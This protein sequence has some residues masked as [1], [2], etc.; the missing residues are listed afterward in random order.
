MNNFIITNSIRFIFLVLLQVLVLN[1]V[2]FFGYINPVLYILF[3]FFYP[4]EKEK[5]TFLIL[6]FLL[7][8]C[9]DFFSNSGGVNAAAI[10]LI[11]YIRLPL[12][13][14]IQNKT[15]FDYLLFN[16]KRL[17][18]IQAIVYVLSLT[19]IHHTVLFILEFY[20]SQISFSIFSKIIITTLLSSLLIGF[21]IQLFTKSKRS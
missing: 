11:A 6:S 5:S 14:I 8:L 12:L 4:L 19:F 3:V 17:N 21:S 9:I 18:F 13:H 15:E 1:H 20:K 2:F 10:L 7:G 16:I